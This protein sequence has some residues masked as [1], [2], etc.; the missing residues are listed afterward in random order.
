MKSL[1][2]L[3]AGLI[4]LAACGKKNDGG[5]IGGGGNG[6]GGGGSLGA[7]T[8]YVQWATDGIQK[9]SLQ[10]GVESTVMPENTSLHSYYIGQD[11]KSMLTSADAPGTD[12]D[13]NLYTLTNLS[14]GTII[15][16]FK[17]YPAEGDYTSP[18]LSPDGSTIAVPPTYDD[19]L[20]IMDLKGN[21]SHNITSFQGKKLASTVVWMPDKTILFTT[22]DGLFRTNAAFTQASVVKQFNFASWGDIAASPD[23]TKIA[24]AGGNHIWMMNADGTNLV[25]VTNSTEVETYPVFSPDGKYLLVG[26][27]YRESLA[28][29]W[30]WNLAIIPADGKQYNVDPGA[31]KNV[32][33]VIPKGQNTAQGGDGSM[34]WR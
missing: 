7:G 10:T 22:S 31:D 6:G 18:T 29:S 5:G 30:L 1:S 3:T 26:T 8:I 33:P 4:L 9:I 15:S 27:N 20:V 23:G 32:V 24:L 21:V 34:Y 16:Q 2:V 25:Q 11:G 28:A 19:G 14:D 12:Y 13:A 17:Y